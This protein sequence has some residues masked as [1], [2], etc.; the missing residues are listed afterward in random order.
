M[1]RTERLTLR[2]I[3]TRLNAAEQGTADEATDEETPVALTWSAM[4]VKRVLNRAGCLTARP[5]E[6]PDRPPS[7]LKAASRALWKD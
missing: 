4:R 5:T 1:W 2:A 6:R 3:A 7:S